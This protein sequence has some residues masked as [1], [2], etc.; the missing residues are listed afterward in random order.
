MRKIVGLSLV[1]FWGGAVHGAY[2]VPGE[3]GFEFGWG[4][5]YPWPG[6]VD[7]AASVQIPFG[8]YTTHIRY[9][10]THYLPIL[11]EHKEYH[12]YSNDLTLGGG[13]HFR[14]EL[15][16]MRLGAYI[17]AGIEEHDWDSPGTGTY[18]GGVRYDLSVFSGENWFDVGSGLSARGSLREG[19]WFRPSFLVPINLSY[20]W[21]RG[22][23]VGLA[24]YLDY[25]VTV[26]HIEYI[27]YGEKKTEM[28]FRGGG[29]FRLGPI[30]YW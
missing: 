8:I 9:R 13:W 6:L 2:E 12:A 18:I 5:L 3:V 24:F 7:L 14:S 26:Y 4:A 22:E 16:A 21:R 29:S 17:G 30:F 15:P 19:T 27:S 20:S 23:N 28:R 11:E 1:F 10:H 25:W